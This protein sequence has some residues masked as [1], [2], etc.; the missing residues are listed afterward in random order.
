[1][2]IGGTVQSSL[3]YCSVLTHIAKLVNNKAFSSEY[4]ELVDNKLIS[5]IFNVLSSRFSTASAEI[6]E[7]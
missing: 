5:T 3:L 4:N 7:M 2:N 6:A 1:M